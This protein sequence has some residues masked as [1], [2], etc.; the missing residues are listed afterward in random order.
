MARGSRRAASVA[1]RCRRRCW[2]TPT[3]WC[4]GSTRRATT[5][6]ARTPIACSR[7]SAGSAEPAQAARPLEDGVEAGLVGD[8][9]V[10]LAQLRERARVILLRLLRPDAHGHAHAHLLLHGGDR[11]RIG[12]A[13][14]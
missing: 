1:C 13:P 11:L 2:S 5:R 4:A 10:L 12:V 9:G 6:C 3:A 14:G 8:R 7:R